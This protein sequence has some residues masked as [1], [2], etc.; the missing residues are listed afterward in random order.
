M[1]VSVEKT[2]VTVE[3]AVE[4]ALAELQADIDDV[5]IEVLEE[6]DS[7]PSLGRRPCRVLV[8][9][10]DTTPLY[11]GDCAGAEDHEVEEAEASAR[12]FVENVLDLF[13]LRYH[14]HVTRD[15]EALN[16][17]I[18]GR[19]CGIIIG[20][21]GETLQALQ[22]LTSL[23]ANRSIDRPLYTHVDAGGYR[24]RHE[25]SLA[26]L[27]RRTAAKV[28]KSGRTFEM[29]PMN[30]SDRRIVHSALQNFRG[31]TTFSEG[32]GDERRV[33]IAPDS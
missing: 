22:Y 28:A 18:E 16:I 2:G 21:G 1:S 13:G 30:P 24:K 25:E 27:A 11:Y 15:E 6:G 31:V 32:E 12:S 10:E 23:V 8:T 4:A 7:D 17:D 29:K 26:S 14:L 19:D 3:A 5:V 9:L 33:I 20:R